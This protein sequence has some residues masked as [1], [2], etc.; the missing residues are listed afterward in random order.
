MVRDVGSLLKSKFMYH[1]VCICYRFLR[2]RIRKGREDTES[3]NRSLR[4]ESFTIPNGS[5][6]K[7]VHVGCLPTVEYSRYPLF[8]SWDIKRSTL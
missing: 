3:Q 5:A 1:S 7:L 6:D 8:K 4:V 2:L